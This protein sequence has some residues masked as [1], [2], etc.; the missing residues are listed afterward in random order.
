MATLLEPDER[1][2]Q[3]VGGVADEV[4]RALPVERDEDDVARDAG[5]EAEGGE[6]GRQGLAA[7]LHL[8]REDAGLL[9]ERTQRGRT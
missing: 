3:V 9:R 2:A 5:I 7:L 8:D 6:G 1:E 4:V